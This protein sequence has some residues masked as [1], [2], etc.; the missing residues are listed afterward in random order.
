[1]ALISTALF[2]R[3]TLA[4]LEGPSRRDRQVTLAVT[5]FLNQD[6]LSRRELDDEISQ[7]CLTSFLKAL[8]PMKLY[9]TQAD[10]DHF[11]RWKNTLDDL[12]KQGQV[13]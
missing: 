7:R 8:D 11:S 1:M 5:S 13:Q 3:A 2:V 12:V 6:H 9:F 4:E 10:V